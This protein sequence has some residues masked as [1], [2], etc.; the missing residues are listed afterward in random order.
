MKRLILCLALVGLPM[1]PARARAVIGAIQGRCLELTLAG[2][3]AGCAG[4]MTI[5]YAIL[6][7]GRT[8]IGVPAA[9]GRVI[10]FVAEK[11]A[12][13]TPGSYFMYLAQVDAHSHATHATTDVGGMCHVAM[14]D[15]AMIWHDVTC[16][17]QDSDGALYSFKF[18]GS[19]QRAKLLP[20]H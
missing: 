14:S 8:M 16:Q 7:N 17:A 2:K 13:P 4:P 1:A 6:G 18:T 10:D 15:D 5:I 20:L 9:D 12:Q 11:D 3:N 19:G